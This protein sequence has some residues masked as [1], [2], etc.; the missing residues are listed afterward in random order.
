MVEMYAHF[1]VVMWIMDALIWALGV[2]FWV[3]TYIAAPLESRKKGYTVSGLPGM[4]V[5]LF[6]VAGYLSPNRWLMLISLSDISVIALV[7]MIC[8]GRICK[9]KSNEQERG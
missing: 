6:L 4:S 9:R 8:K 5:F 1:P 2:F 7:I 3:F